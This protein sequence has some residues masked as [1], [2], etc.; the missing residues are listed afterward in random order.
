MNFSLAYLRH[1]FNSNEILGIQLASIHN[2]GFYLNL[3]KNIKNAIEAD[4]F[5]SF[6]KEFLSKYQ[7]VA[8]NNF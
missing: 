5:L 3:M 8:E 4:T 6:K 1:L 2:V 7:V